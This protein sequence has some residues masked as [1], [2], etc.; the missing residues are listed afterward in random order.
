M[1]REIILSA[2]PHAAPPAG[3]QPLPGIQNIIAIGSG[4]G[5]VGKTTVAVNLAIALC[6]LGHRVGLLDGD[7]YGPNVPLMMGALDAQPMALAGNRI[8]RIEQYGLKLN[9]VG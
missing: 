4:K 9:S 1:K 3:P 8:H 5:G 7:I 6:K 2:H